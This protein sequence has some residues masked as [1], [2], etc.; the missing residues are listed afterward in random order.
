M[1]ILLEESYSENFKATNL[2]SF[3][4]KEIFGQNY[5]LAPNKQPGTL[6]FDLEFL[7]TFQLVA[8]VNTHNS[9]NKDRSSK[10]IR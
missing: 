7:E 1:T 6:L 5:W 2:L 9:H 4:E 8:L 3:G 10:Q